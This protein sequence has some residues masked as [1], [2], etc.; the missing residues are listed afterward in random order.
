MST[1]QQLANSV[2]VA[3]HILNTVL[4]GTTVKREVTRPLSV[5][6]ALTALLVQKNLGNANSSYCHTCNG[7]S[8]Q[9][10]SSNCFAGYMYPA[11]SKSS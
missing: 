10:F 1:L 7:V 11:N 8:V 6:W 2:I 9:R 4:Q 3:L 5:S